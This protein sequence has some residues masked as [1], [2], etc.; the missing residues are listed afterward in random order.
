ML[1]KDPGWKQGFNPYS[2]CPL[3][4]GNFFYH[5][6]A[7]TAPFFITHFNQWNNVQKQKKIKYCDCGKQKNKDSDCGQQKEYTKYCHCGK[8]KNKESDCEQQKE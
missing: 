8:Q 6:V 4:L 5:T 7:D 3:K 2:G 1:K